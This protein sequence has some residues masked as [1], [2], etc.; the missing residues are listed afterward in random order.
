MLRLIC[1]VIAAFAA[2]VLAAPCQAEEPDWKVGLAQVK[3]TPERPI[4]LAGYASRNRPFEK[5]TTELYAKALAVEDRSGKI[6][7]LVTTDLIGIT[8]AI[9]EPICERVAAKSG[10]KREQ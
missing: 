4:F 8:A 2:S 1:V 6:G 7:V 5:T 3:I 10:L 9:G